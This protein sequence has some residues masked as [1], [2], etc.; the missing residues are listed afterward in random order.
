MLP[1]IASVPFR[2]AFFFFLVTLPFLP[3]FLLDLDEIMLWLFF[4]LAQ[5]YSPLSWLSQWGQRVDS[6]FEM[7]RANFQI[8]K[9]K[10]GGQTKWGR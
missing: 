10:R 8:P 4:C 6:D 3:F 1:A 2:T 9:K 7:R 5:R